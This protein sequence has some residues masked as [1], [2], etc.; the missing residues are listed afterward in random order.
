MSEN[1]VTLSLNQKEVLCLATLCELAEKHPDTLEKLAEASDLSAVDFM[2]FLMRM[3][4]EL[5]DGGPG[6]AEDSE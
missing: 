6:A 3:E 1:R 5:L 4:F 2:G